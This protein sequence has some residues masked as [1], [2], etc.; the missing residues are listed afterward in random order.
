[1]G[2]AL[3]LAKRFEKALKKLQLKDSAP[4]FSTTCLASDSIDTSSHF[5]GR[6]SMP[7][8]QLV[9]YRRKRRHKNA[10]SRFSKRKNR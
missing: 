8:K 2:F 7:S 10:I 5:S 1:M 3:T 9:M 6:K 4:V